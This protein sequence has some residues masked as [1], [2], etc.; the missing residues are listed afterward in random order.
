MWGTINPCVFYR[1]LYCKKMWKLVRFGVHGDVGDV[2]VKWS[3]NRLFVFV[4]SWTEIKRNIYFK[5]TESSP[6]T[7]VMHCAVWNNS[8]QIK[9]NLSK[10][11]LHLSLIWTRF[12]LTY[13]K[14]SQFWAKSRRVLKQQFLKT[15]EMY[16]CS[17]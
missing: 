8:S 9:A 17:S 11:K 12:N 6:F 2:A 14:L 16:L 7:T 3:D 5:K 13:T 1:E 10:T 15:V 4:K